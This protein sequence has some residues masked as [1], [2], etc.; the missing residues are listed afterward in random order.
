MDKLYGKEYYERCAAKGIDY[1]FY[2]NWQ[3]QYAKMV[4]YVSGIF[5]SEIGE[6]TFLD[7]G[8]ACGVNLRAFKETSIFTNHVGIDVSEFLVKLGNKVN[9]FKEGELIVDDSTILKRIPDESIDFLHCSQ[10]MEHLNIDDAKKSI[11]HIY[12]VM[13]QGATGFITLNAIKQGQTSE[14]VTSQDPTHITVLKE[15]EWAA[16]FEKFQIKSDSE[17]LLKK[18]KFY[19]GDDGKNFYQHYYDDWSVFVI[20]KP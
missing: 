10:L 16:L 15:G 13:K 3:K 5:K 7:V 12:R 4:I 14:D 20:I 6:K 1:A 18:A 17:K 2:G 8:T 11:H 19:P 9:G